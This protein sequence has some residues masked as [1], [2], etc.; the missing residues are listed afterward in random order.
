MGTAR[1]AMK[2]SGSLNP[3]TFGNP[4]Q[5]IKNKV[6]ISHH[7]KQACSWQSP[8]TSNIVSAQVETCFAIED[9]GGTATYFDDAPAAPL[10]ILNRLVL[11]ARK[12]LATGSV[13]IS[14]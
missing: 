3:S 10:P 11:V 12:L 5:Q 9:I 8:V 7:R 13:D 2:R 6:P 14:Q 1:R 4:Q